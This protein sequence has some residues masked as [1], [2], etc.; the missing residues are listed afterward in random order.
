MS[1]MKD[2]LISKVLPLAAVAGG[3]LLAV[4]ALQGRPGVEVRTPGRDRDKGDAGPAAASFNPTIIEPVKYDGKPADIPGAWPNF[5]GPKLDGISHE[6]TPLARSW[7]AGGPKQLWGVEL[8]EG[9]AGPAILGGKVYLLDYDPPDTWLVH[10]WEVK[11]YKA[12]ATRIA[13]GKTDPAVARLYECLDDKARAAIASAAKGDADDAHRAAVVAGLSAVIER[14]DFYSPAAFKALKLPLEYKRLLIANEDGTLSQ[15]AEIEHSDVM[16]LNRMVLEAMLA[17]DLA[18][19]RHGDVMR[20]LSL[21]DGKDI[22]RFTY[23]VKV[24]RNHG[25]SR[26]VPAVTDKYVVSLGPKCH[27][28]CLDAQTGKCH[29][30]IDLVGQYGTEEPDWYAG[31]CPLIDDGKVILAPGGSGGKA[32]MMA[33]ELG[34]QKKI[35]WETPNPNNWQMTHSSIVPMDFG[36]KRMYVYCGSG[37]V[38][39]VDAATGEILWQTT[40]W[41]IGIANVPTPVVVGDGRIFFSGGYDSGCAM[42]TLTKE[43]GKFGIDTLWRLGADVFGSPQQTPILYK[44]HIFGVRPDGQMACLT[45][46]GKLAWAS[47]SGAKFGQAYGPYLIADG[48]LYIVNDTG[49]MT[50]AEADT[51]QW[52]KLASAKVLTGHDSWGP[53]AIVDGRL[54]VRDLTR[55][56]CL[57]VKK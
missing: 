17:P 29:W 16:R 2:L 52:K 28:V 55:M 18:V 43:D 9:Y 48:L 15:R 25:M 51:S 10:P 49:G 36:G 12:L 4:L 32:L 38:V 47:G 46:D 1:N 45:L 27:V 23:P 44:D 7:P 21:A 26:T 41:K 54:L 24:K 11:D 5:R 6:A 20:C 39:G 33:L 22:W 42:M 34:P 31:Q 3:V 50:L 35:L 30:G 19:S 40:A 57:D 37:G 56:V 13:E 53:M 14:K 8:G